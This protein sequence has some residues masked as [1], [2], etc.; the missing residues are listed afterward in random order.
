[1]ERIELDC[2]SAHLIFY[3]KLEYKKATASTSLTMAFIMQTDAA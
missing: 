3:Q 1:M 2:K